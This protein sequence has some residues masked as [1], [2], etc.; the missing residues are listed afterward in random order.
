MSRMINQSIHD[1]FYEE[2]KRL[3]KWDYEKKPNMINKSILAILYGA[4]PRDLLNKISPSILV[5]I[6]TAPEKTKTT[7]I[8]ALYKDIG[9]SAL[10]IHL[11]GVVVLMRASPN[12]KIFNRLFNRAYKPESTED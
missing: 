5:T 8:K 2:L 11:A 6:Q 3:K 7:T 9:K 1:S 4:L 12:W 10:N